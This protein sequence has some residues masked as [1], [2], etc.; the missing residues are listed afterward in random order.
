MVSVRIYPNRSAIHSPF[1]RHPT[2][3]LPVARPVPHSIEFI[4]TVRNGQP[5]PPVVVIVTRVNTGI[6]YI[7]AAADEITVKYIAHT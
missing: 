6:A 5:N 4:E 1:P 3:L 7:G 2:Q